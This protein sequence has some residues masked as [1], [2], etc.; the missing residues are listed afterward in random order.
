[1]Q[2]GRGCENKHGAMSC[3]DEGRW[4]SR[5]EE[6]R[7][8]TPLGWE[9]KCLKLEG[10]GR[11]VA[12]SELLRLKKCSGKTR[13]HVYRNSVGTFSRTGPYRTSSSP[14]LTVP[15]FSSTH[16]IVNSSTS[17][18]LYHCTAQEYHHH[19]LTQDLIRLN[20]PLPPLTSPNASAACRHSHTKP[21]LAQSFTISSRLDRRPR[22]GHQG[23]SR[24][25]QERS[26]RKFTSAR[27][28]MI[29]Q[30]MNSTGIRERNSNSSILP[31]R[32][33]LSVG[34]T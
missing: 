9:K 7:N 6:P 30:R 5:R 26:V 3:S 19:H 22:H 20:T 29:S 14:Q 15:V 17:V 10:L 16:D 12:L 32:I 23:P 13:G 4:S 1:M 21:T 2:L 31:C 24:C 34:F 8:R 27:A 25:R 33:P 11:T 28:I 18:P